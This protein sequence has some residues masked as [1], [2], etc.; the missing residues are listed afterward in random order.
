MVN[1]KFSFTIATGGRLK[2]AK[3]HFFGFF[4]IL[5][6]WVIALCYFSYFFRAISPI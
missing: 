4:A 1:F 5:N 3:T 6:F 2:I